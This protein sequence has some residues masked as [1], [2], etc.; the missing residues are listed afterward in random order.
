MP[1]R[2]FEDCVPTATGE[3]AGSTSASQF[4]TITAQFV[5][6]L[7]KSDNA[8]SVYIGV[9]NTVTKADGTTDTTTGF[10]LTAKDRVA[11]PTT[12]LNRFW[13]ICDN[14]GDDVMYVVYNA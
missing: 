6:F 13:L 1:L 5:E 8:G 3:K 14:A 4:A 12:N 7:A 10:E 2:Q 9:A 11:F